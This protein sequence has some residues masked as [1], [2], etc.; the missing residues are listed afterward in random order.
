MTGQQ[1][2]DRQP[3]RDE[4]EA[5]PRHDG[6]AAGSRAGI[7]AIRGAGVPGRRGGGATSGAG[8]SVGPAACAAG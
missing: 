3:R 5:G 8:P 6:D 1:A 2:A 7:G 4:T